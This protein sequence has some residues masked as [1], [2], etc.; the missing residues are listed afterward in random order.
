M[1]ISVLMSVYYKEKPEYLEKAIESIINQTYKPKQ[2]VV[3]KDGKLTEELDA[4]IDKYKNEYKELID[5]FELRE[6]NGLGLALKFGV[7]KCKSDYIARMDSDD[8]SRKDR[9]EKQVQFLEKNKSIDILG[10]YIQEYDKTMKKETFIKKVSLNNFDIYNEI[11]VKNPFNHQ[12][13]IFKKKSVL[14]VGNYR[15]CKIE[16]YDLWVRMILNKMNMANIEDILVD[17]RTSYD[18]Y[19][20]RTGIKYL[21]GILEIEKQL[22]DNKIINKAQYLKNIIS[23]TILAFI[24][25][26]IKM[27]IYPKLIRKLKWK[28]K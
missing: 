25:A 6:N 22:L 13:V 17:Y 7:E 26:K 10:G 2:I 12:T 24:P 28:M 20:R 27:I 3:I 1:D 11:K 9:F 8:I 21:Q 15:N 19:K 14:E 5:I 4:V 18:M 16:D 23:R